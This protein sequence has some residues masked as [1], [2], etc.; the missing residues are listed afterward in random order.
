MMASKLKKF[1]DRKQ[2]SYETIAHIAAVTA[3]EIAAKAH[4]PGREFA[5][6]VMVRLDDHLAMAV[7]RADMMVNLDAL[8]KVT[9][10][11]RAD[12]ASEADFCDLFPECETGAMPPFGNLYG[13]EVFVDAMLAEDEEIVFNAGTHEELVKM[14]YQD[15]ERLVDPVRANLAWKHG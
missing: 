12:L 6:T 9:G 11:K 10:A 1:L 8:Q 5:K 3:Q 14:S 13:L 4:V 2:V 7:L 15:F